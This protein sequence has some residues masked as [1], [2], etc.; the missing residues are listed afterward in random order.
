MVPARMPT[1]AAP[2][3]LTPSRSAMK[4]AIGPDV[5]GS[6]TSQPP[7]PGPHRR[8]ARLAAPI[9]SGVRTSFRTRWS[10]GS[11]R[12]TGSTLAGG[13]GRPGDQDRPG[14]SGRAA[15]VAPLVLVRRRELGEGPPERGQEED[16]VV[17]KAP[18]AARRVRQLALGD[19]LDKSLR[20][21]RRR[22][23]EGT[24]E[25]RRAP[26]D[27]RQLGEEPRGALGVGEAEPPV[28]RR[29][30][31]RPAFECVHLEPRVVADGH[32]PRA[33]RG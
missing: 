12:G 15:A 25:A 9:R 21:P 19:T 13:P 4:K 20:P 14:R 5:S 6:P 31:T 29:G 32:G 26:P 22:Q 30:G 2:A 24:A 8:P 16:R 7:T 17:A 18:V 27:V 11:S 3:K 1:A 10:T 33:R 28:A 23:R